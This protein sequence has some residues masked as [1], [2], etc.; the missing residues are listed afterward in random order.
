MLGENQRGLCE[1]HHSLRERL[2]ELG[3]AGYGVDFPA[4]A[5]ATHAAV[6]VKVDSTVAQSYL[7]RLKIWEDQIPSQSDCGHCKG[8]LQAA[9]YSFC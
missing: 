4:V 3:A 9:L 2:V 1:I 6:V 8:S 5:G 7:H